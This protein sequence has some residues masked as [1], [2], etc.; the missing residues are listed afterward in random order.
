MHAPYSGQVFI[1]RRFNHILEQFANHFVAQRRDA[2]LFPSFHQF[3]N[4]PCARI[5]FARA[6]RPLDR[7]HRIFQ[8]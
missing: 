3:A 1:A 7:K 6:G 2:N 8:S 4:H 5:G